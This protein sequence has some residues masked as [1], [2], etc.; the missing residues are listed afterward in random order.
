MF[1]EPT[2]EVVIKYYRRG[3]YILSLTIHG[4]SMQIKQLLLFLWGFI[5]GSDVNSGLDSY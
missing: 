3:N 4:F 2:S 1:S 5:S